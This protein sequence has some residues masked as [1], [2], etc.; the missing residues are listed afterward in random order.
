MSSRNL[1][2][3][4][5]SE[6]LISIVVIGIIAS[7]TLPAIITNFQQK[8]RLLSLNKAYNVLE[9]NLTSLQTE[10]YYKGSLTKSI[11]SLAN[12]KSNT[13]ETSAGT[14]LKQYYKIANDCGKATSEGCF[15]SKYST[16]SGSSADFT[17]KYGSR[18]GYSVLLKDSSALCIIPADMS[19]EYF[20]SAMVF[21]D[22]NGPKKPNIAGKDLFTF[23]IYN[24]FTIDEIEPK[25][26][27]KPGMEQR[28]R[29][30]TNP[31][32]K[33]CFESILLN[34]WKIVY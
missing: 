17:C 6:A 2:A 9:Q 3:F 24:D 26:T 33:S 7:L 4:T 19:G 29:T 11:L 22:V 20:T 34:N 1:Q 18:E 21:V 12:P 5:L 25:A 8:S 23:N 31:L 30:Y 15:A 14:F 28:C 13:V 27:R 32:A 10:R 16:L